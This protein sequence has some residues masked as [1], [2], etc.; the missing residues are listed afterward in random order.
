MSERIGADRR[1]A[2]CGC[3][4]SSGAAVKRGF[5]DY[6]KHCSSI[7]D[8]VRPMPTPRLSPYQRIVRNAE[9]GMGVRLTPDEVVQMAS[10]DSITRQAKVDDVDAAITRKVE[11]ALAHRAGVDDG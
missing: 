8:R 5:L 3:C 2:R 7:L 11:D 10:E 4:I 6:H 1:C 9:L